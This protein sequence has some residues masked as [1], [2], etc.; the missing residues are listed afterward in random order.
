MGSGTGSYHEMM[1]KALNDEAW[2]ALACAHPHN[3]FLFF[4]VEYGLIGIWA[5]AYYFYRPLRYGGGLGL[6]HQALLAGFMAVFVVD[7]LTHG[8][9]WLAR[10]NFFFSFILALLAAGLTVSSKL[11]S[12]S[13][14]QAGP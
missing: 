5:L 14:H 10:E 6:R 13:A 11:S 4:G 9:M 8:P 3:Q 7:S 2:C 12:E 1:R